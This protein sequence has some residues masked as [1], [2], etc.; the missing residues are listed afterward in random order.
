VR[1][2]VPTKRGDELIYSVLTAG[3]PQ[4]L[5]RGVR[6]AAATTRASVRAQI[7][8]QGPFASSSSLDVWRADLRVRARGHHVS[9]I[10]RAG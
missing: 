7:G 6:A 4:P 2:R 5:R 1:V 9:F 3:R 8:L 10:T